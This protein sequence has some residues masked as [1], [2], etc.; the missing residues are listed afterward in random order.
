[1]LLMSNYSTSASL[2][3]PVSSWKRI[4]AVQA[5]LE[6][7]G[8]QLSG[9]RADVARLHDSLTQAQAAAKSAAD[10]SAMRVE[11]LTT[12]LQQT[13]SQ[14]AQVRHTAHNSWSSVC[15][16]GTHPVARCRMHAC[17]GLQEQIKRTVA[18]SRWYHVLTQAAAEGERLAAEL[19]SERDMAT[20]LLPRPSSQ[21]SELKHLRLVCVPAGCS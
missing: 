12:Q 15:E 16:L 18:L 17:C 9:A 20:C 3:C 1:M 7:T 19:A 5:E 11:T 2:A 4:C 8:Q 6:S 13:A 21:G 14:A 10:A